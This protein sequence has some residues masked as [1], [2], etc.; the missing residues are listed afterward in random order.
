[1]TRRAGHKLTHLADAFPVRERGG[2]QEEK[3]EDGAREGHLCVFSGVSA[4]RR[5]V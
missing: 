5:C 2:E 3:G 1:M 4:A